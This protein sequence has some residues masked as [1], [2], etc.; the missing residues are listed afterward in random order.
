MSFLTKYGTQWGA[1]PMTAGQI[2]W[3]APGSSYT[4]DGKSYP[5]SDGN[6][7]LSPE[8]ALASIAQAVSN[9]SANAGDVICLLPGT[10][11]VATAS[12]A[13]SKAGLTL[14]GL[15]YFPQGR[16]SR[17]AQM[18][19]QPKA[20]VTTSV[21]ADEAFNITAADTTFAN[22]V[23][24]PITGAAFANFTTAAHRLKV[25]DC[26]IDL[27]TPAGAAST[28]GF[29]PTGATQAPTYISFVNCSAEEDNA[30]TSQS[31][32]IDTGAAAPFLI[33]NCSFWKDGNTG[34]SAAW[35]V[36]VQ[37]RDNAWGIIRDCDIFQCTQ[38][39]AIAGGS[40]TKGFNGVDMTILE[41]INI[42]GCRAAVSVTKPVD[43]FG[44]GDVSLCNN[45]VATVA[46]GT[47][48]TLITATT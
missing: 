12:V 5:A 38:T 39:A 15:P 24:R 19:S 9:A 34:S 47:G 16:I 21:A 48:G 2:H 40:I 30:G 13:L 23:A 33:D 32:A 1:I 42:F 46:G 17:A 41:S 25:V 4:V 11:T 14:L 45:Y 29:V 36:A 22:I 6:D 10:H 18:F 44:A 20:I 3:V 43:D 31:F 35:A 27:K 7:G 37:I 28:A 8:R 26:H